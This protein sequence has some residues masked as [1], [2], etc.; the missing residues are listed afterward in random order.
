[1]KRQVRE[2]V[3]VLC[4]SCKGKRVVNCAC[5]DCQ[6]RGNAVNKMLTEQQGVPVLTDCKRCSGRGFE[7]I[8]STEV[9]AAVCQITD[10]ITLDTWKKSVKPFY[11]QLI[12]KFD[13]EEA[14]AE[15]QLKR[16]TR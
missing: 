4:T 2:T 8:P 13:I 15:A 9:H 16:I 11:D 14:W 5:N 3:K 12:T 1:M 7:R 10:A 6:G